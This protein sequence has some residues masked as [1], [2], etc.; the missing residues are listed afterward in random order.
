MT[1]TPGAEGHV[2]LSAPGDGVDHIFGFLAEDDHKR[3][4]VE[5]SVPSE[6]SFVVVGIVGKHQA[7]R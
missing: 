3:I 1:A 2:M 4:R 7:A 6:P 5:L